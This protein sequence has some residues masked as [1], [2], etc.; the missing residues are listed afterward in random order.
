MIRV[1]V[2]WKR[3]DILQT[4]RHLDLH[5]F[6]H[7]AR[8]IQIQGVFAFVQLQ[9]LTDRS[10]RNAESVSRE[11]QIELCST[12]TSDEQVGHCPIQYQLDF[13]CAVL[14]VLWSQLQPRQC[15]SRQNPL[16][17]GFKCTPN[18][19]WFHLH[20][21]SAIR[22]V[23]DSLKVDGCRADCTSII[24][25]RDIGL[26]EHHVFACRCDGRSHQGFA[27][28]RCNQITLVLQILR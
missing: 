21:H 6:V 3:N 15:C 4:R 24:C 8:H 28:R 22:V 27:L 25:K 23:V 20:E 18:I 19:R 2:L 14:H 10:Q 13:L 5:I 16:D 17:R 26:Y 12:T 7:S 11:R 9:T 1:L